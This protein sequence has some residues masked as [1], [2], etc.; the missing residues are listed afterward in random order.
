[1]RS[2]IAFLTFAGV[3]CAQTSPPPPPSPQAGHTGI[4]GRIYV[5]PIHPGPER[6]G[7]LNSKPLANTTFV[8]T[9]ESGANSEFTTDDQGQFKAVL[10]PGHYTVTKKG[11]QQKIGRCGPWDALVVAG[12]FNHVEWRCDSGMR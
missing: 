10:T 5:A 12:Q 1:M 2:L 11:A 6:P 3:C 8:A 4:E 9:N 7:V